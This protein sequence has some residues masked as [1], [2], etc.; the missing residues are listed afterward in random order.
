MVRYAHQSYNKT[1]LTVME[2]TTLEPSS[3][4]LANERVQSVICLAWTLVRC[5]SRDLMLY[6][7]GKRKCYSLLLN[8]R[9]RS[10][11]YIMILHCIQITSNA[12]QI[13][14]SSN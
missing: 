12:I 13:L 6:L 2:H 1:R 8:R 14:P 3:R 5:C 11:A 7:Y 9:T 4:D 10:Q